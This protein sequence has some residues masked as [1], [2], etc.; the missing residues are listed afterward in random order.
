MSGVGRGPEG[1]GL[2]NARERE[3]APLLQGVSLVAEG[4]V[5]TELSHEAAAALGTV[6]ASHRHTPLKQ[7]L[8][9]FRF[10]PACVSVA[11]AGV[12]ATEYEDNT[13]WPALWKIAEYAGS[14]Q[15]Q[16]VWGQAFTQSLT[17][18][19]LPAFSGIGK[20]YL[21]PILMHAG[22]PSNCLGDLLRLLLEQAKRDPGLDADSFM[23]WAL[24][25]QRRLAAL[26]K[27]VQR[28]LLNGGEYA[29][30][31]L[32][33]IM[34]LLSRLHDPEPD[35]FGIGLP[36]R[37][38]A[39]A[40]SLVE[41]KVLHLSARHRWAPSRAAQPRLMLD[42][43]GGGPVVA[44]PPV[45]DLQHEWRVVVDGQPHSVTALSSW[46]SDDERDVE[47]SI[48]RPVRQVQV[49]S[50]K[51]GPAIDLPVVDEADPL[52]VFTE[53]GRP[54]PS[55]RSLP[56]DVVWALYPG[57][58]TLTWEGDAHVV[59]EAPVSFGW[60]GWILEQVD[61]T[62]ASGLGL[63]GG[64][65]RKV[66]GTG[67]PRLV[68]GE[69]IAGITSTRGAPVYGRVPLLQLPERSGVG[70]PWEVQ[71]RDLARPDAAPIRRKTLGGE[72]DLWRSLPR[73]VTGTFEITVVG[74]LGFRLDRHI[75]IAEG[76]SAEFEPPVRRLTWD[77]PEPAIAGLR[78]SAPV[79]SEMVFSEHEKEKVIVYGSLRLVVAPPRIEVLR[80]DGVPGAQ[81]SSRPVTIATESFAGHGALL[82]RGPAEVGLSALRAGNDRDGDLQTVESSG[83]CAPGQG[84][85]ELVRLNDT[86][87]RHRRLDLTVDVD[88]VPMPVARIRPRAVATG[89]TL[90]GG[91]LR[92]RDFAVAPGVRLGVYSVYRPWRGAIEL[93]VSPKGTAVVPS[94]LRNAGPLLVLPRL[95]NDDTAWPYW[96]DPEEAL[97]CA[98][99]GVP[100]SGDADEAA[101]TRFLTGQDALPDTPDLERLWLL[102]ALAESLGEFAVRDDLRAQCA[103]YMRSR[104]KAAL[105]ALAVTRLA[106]ETCLVHLIQTGLGGIQP[107]EHVDPVETRGLWARLPGAAAI[108]SGRMLLRSE[109]RSAVLE[110]VVPLYGPEA[111][112]LLNDGAGP[113]AGPA[114]A[115]STAVP[116][117]SL[118]PGRI[119]ALVTEAASNSS[120]A[121][122]PAAEAE[123]EAERVLS[124]TPY[125]RLVEHLTAR[126]AGPAR[127][128]IACALVARA[129]AW[130][131]NAECKQFERRHRDRWA[132]LARSAP[133][134]VA[135]DL[136]SAQAL[137]AGAERAAGVGRQR[138]RES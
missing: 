111:A 122:P 2:L 106:P 110:V 36:E 67:Q 101:L 9:I 112:D 34:L 120:P 66:R 108:V 136:V 77:G 70:R 49:S 105:L 43:L 92:L 39:E 91:K 18:L 20:T 64:P 135:F 80:D 121:D 56:K 134:L 104:P 58:R 13:F 95:G 137:V 51:G 6:Y 24:S 113:Y 102:C 25:G 53:S 128:S 125:A 85:F 132:D 41:R 124:R 14:P 1:R 133:E 97:A 81:W 50:S 117:S 52:L 114:K 22:I 28:F 99:D 10:W 94:D 126:P 83:R 55:T 3:W 88:G 40:M 21:G 59:Y 115:E 5:A 17:Q 57:D 118:S 26:H 61:L 72:I 63:D 23:S 127:L 60:Y 86:V 65:L 37:L 107:R 48:P 62:E 15:D 103:M 68:T 45:A 4:E 71:L 116:R 31:T 131:G 79:E 119:S 109:T 130:S 12:A 98:A 138:D 123:A 76:L 46:A 93:P 96:P 32:D 89:V 73:P 19:G 30:D 44:L 11:L 75:T 33:R 69:P 84:R 47:F 100:V 8:R 90:D 129:G 87:E 82:V 27:P 54:L 42:P 38:V 35:L 78:G 7:K 74:P 29:H 16:T